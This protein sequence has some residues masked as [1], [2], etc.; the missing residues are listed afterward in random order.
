MF[1]RLYRLLLI[2]CVYVSVTKPTC[3]AFSAW[4]NTGATR[5]MKVTVKNIMLCTVVMALTSMLCAA[6]HGQS[7]VGSMCDCKPC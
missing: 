2:Y 1:V 6:Q 7:N 4:L 5:S 3:L